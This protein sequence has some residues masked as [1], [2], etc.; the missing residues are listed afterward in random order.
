MREDFVFGIIFRPATRNPLISGDEMTLPTLRTAFL[1]LTATLVLFPVAASAQQTFANWSDPT[2]FDLGA[3][4]ASAATSNPVNY[5]G[6]LLGTTITADGAANYPDIWYSPTP[7]VGILWSL[8]SIN[9]AVAG[10]EGSID[11][12]V[13]FSEP[14]VDPR[15]HFLNLDNGTA[16]FGTA[17]VILLSG[18]PIFDVTGNVVNATPQPAT[19][20]G[21]QDA[22]GGGSNGA[23]GTVELTGAFTSVTFTVLDTDTSTGSGDGFLWTVSIDPSLSA[24]TPIPTLSEWM[25]VLLALLL[26]TA[27]A[28]RLRGLARQPTAA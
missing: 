7:P 21:C 28:V 22:A 13:T 14:V 2:H 4:T 23:C 16:D 6:D 3:V 18:N 11:V 9:N 8:G 27:A 12:T 1:A 17:P 26:G 10:S 5:G 24:A 20:S 25:L 15:F 19:V